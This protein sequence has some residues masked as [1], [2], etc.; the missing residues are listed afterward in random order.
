MSATRDTKLLTTEQLSANNDKTGKDSD[1][2]TIKSTI[3]QMGGAVEVFSS[4][5]NGTE[6]VIRIKF[7]LASEKDMQQE[8][9]VAKEAGL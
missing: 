4:P 2:A 5:E 7:R 8:I 3:E 6:I 9:T 1:I